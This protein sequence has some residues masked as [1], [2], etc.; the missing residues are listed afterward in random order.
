[1]N[2][3]PDRS[4]PLACLEQRNRSCIRTFPVF[5]WT[6]TVHFVFL[7]LFPFVSNGEESGTEKFE[8]AREC[9][10]AWLARIGGRPP[11]PVIVPS[12]TIS[13]RQRFFFISLYVWAFFC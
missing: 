7:L 8:S 12:P 3:Q 11:R 9:A 1:M 5:C 4:S 6:V 13:N 2:R 10:G